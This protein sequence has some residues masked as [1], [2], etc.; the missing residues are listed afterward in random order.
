MRG[1]IVVRIEARLV[2]IASK[3][4]LRV[5]NI[6]KVMLKLMH[7]EIVQMQGLRLILGAWSIE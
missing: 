1:D 5:E 4:S 2:R 6:H 7:I 3:V